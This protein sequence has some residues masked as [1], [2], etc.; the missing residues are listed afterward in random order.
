MRFI[1]ALMYYIVLLIYYTII[2]MLLWNNL[3]LVC[4][5]KG[6][7]GNILISYLQLC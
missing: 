4:S 5:S 6:N 3:R 7:D 1:L 2:R